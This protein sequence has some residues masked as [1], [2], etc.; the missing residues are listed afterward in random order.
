[1]PRG[2]DL[3]LGEYVIWENNLNR[4]TALNVPLTSLLIQPG[5]NFLYNHCIIPTFILNDLF[6]P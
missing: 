3:L 2:R 5:L 4:H 1:M 6:L